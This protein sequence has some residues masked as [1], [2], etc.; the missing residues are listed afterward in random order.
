MTVIARMYDNDWFVAHASPRARVQLA[1]AVAEATR[2]CESAADEAARAR[3]TS[4]AAFAVALS[5]GNAAQAALDRA[6]ANAAAAARC[7]HIVDGHAFSVETTA[8]GH[9]RR[10]D[11]RSCTLN[12]SA[13]LTL[14]GKDE[15]WSAVLHDPDPR[16]RTKPHVT[17]GTDPWDALHR[18]F[19]WIATGE[20]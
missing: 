1:E 17:L 9:A 14:N 20:L 3:G 12:R 2:D 13:R 8:E 7:T 15:P 16:A 6:R 10:L 4:A 19:H 18:M 5:H 11:V